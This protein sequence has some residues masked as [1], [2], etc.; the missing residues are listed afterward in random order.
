ML[1]L[2]GELAVGVAVYGVRAGDNA[3]PVVVS[4]AVAALPGI[5]GEVNL[6]CRVGIGDYAKNI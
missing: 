1:T 3:W 5:A 2:L 6:R 4:L